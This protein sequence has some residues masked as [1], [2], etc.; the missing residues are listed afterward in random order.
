VFVPGKPLQPILLF[1]VRPEP[2]QVKH[3]SGAPL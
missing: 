1:A 3:P 2:T